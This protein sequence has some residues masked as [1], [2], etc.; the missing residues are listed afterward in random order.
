M[1]P[2]SLGSRFNPKTGRECVIKAL[3]SFARRPFVRNVA[4]VA[5]GTAASQAITMAFA[6]LITRLYGPEAFGLQGIFMSVLSLL[7]VIAALGYPIAIVLPKLDADAIGLVRLSILIGGCMT[8]LTTLTIYL[9]G[10]DLLRLLNAEAIAAFI[11]L[12]PVAMFFGVLGSVLGQ[13][14]IRKKAFA[15]SAKYGVFTTLMISTAKAALGILHPT[16]MILIVTNTVGICVGTAITYAGWRKEAAKQ[17]ATQVKQQAATLR[18][19]ARQHVD[20][21]LLRT[22]QNLINAFSQSLPVL[23][24]AGYFGASASGQYAIALA[25]LGM[26]A[27]LVGSSIMAVFYPRINEA[28]QNGENARALIVKATAGMAA[29]GALPFLA[30]TFAGPFLFEFTFGTE[31]RTAG[32]YAQWLSLWL[33]LQHVNK[34]AVSAIPA[35]RLQGGLLVYELFSTGAKFLALWLGFMIFKH[36]VTAIAL[37]SVSG[38]IAYIWL[39]IWVVQRSGGTNHHERTETSR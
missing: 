18:Q 14:L 1:L 30:V 15:L 13:W 21:P 38:V 35:L 31:W 23:L 8:T 19:L 28:I 9:L 6:P 7:A 11:Y 34:P 16:A 2:F 22:P 33:F 29:M 4:T 36:D 24:L 12:I 32:V 17:T 3:R 37:F 27:S 10:A 5:S 25:V 39:I 20:F 26:P